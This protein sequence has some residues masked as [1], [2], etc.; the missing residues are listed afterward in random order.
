MHRDRSISEL[1]R[2][3]DRFAISL[4][5]NKKPIPKGRAFCLASV[6]IPLGANQDNRQ[7]RR[8]RSALIFDRHTK[9][10]RFDSLG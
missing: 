6:V 5:P 10:L 1:F 3:L 9:R 8:R 4:M 7:R 2:R